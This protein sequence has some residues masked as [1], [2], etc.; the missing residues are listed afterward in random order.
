ME[1]FQGND[2]W[3]VADWLLQQ[4]LEKLVNIFKGMLCF[5]FNVYFNLTSHNVKANGECVYKFA[6]FAKN[7]I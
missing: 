3:F 5:N 1:N 4:G 2:Q 6:Y 7:C